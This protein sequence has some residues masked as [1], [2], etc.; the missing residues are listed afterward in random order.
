[1]LDHLT[2]APARLI[3]FVVRLLVVFVMAWS[4]CAFARSQTPA[5]LND[6]GRERGIQLYKDGN[7]KAA[8]D[9]LI[10]V[11]KRDKRDVDAWYYLGL[12]LTRNNQITKG[13]QAF[14]AATTL[15]PDFGPAHT[16]LAYTL[17]L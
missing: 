5:G 17:M 12:A 15:L 3:S 9:V 16:G 11:V 6:T 13:R 8:I 1:M 4:C 2:L 7:T 10:S 14:E